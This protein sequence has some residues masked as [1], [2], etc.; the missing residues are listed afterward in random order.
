MDSRDIENKSNLERD[1]GILISNYLL[2]N[3]G[4]QIGLIDEI[5]DLMYGFKGGK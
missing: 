3:K 5:I 2:L 1:L 4:E